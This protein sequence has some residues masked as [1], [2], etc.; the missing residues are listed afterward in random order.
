[1]LKLNV[2]KVGGA[3]IE[4]EAK[5]LPFLKDFAA[6]KGPKIL[7]HGGG[8][9]ASLWAE[10]MGI[11]VQM[12]DGRRI[13]DTATLEL[14]SGIYAGQVNKTIVAHL[15]AFGCNALGLSGADGNA[16]RA[17]KRPVKAIDYGFVGDVKEVNANL[18]QQ[19]LA[20]LLVPVCCAL[21]H[22]GN[23]QLLNTNADT[24]TAEIGKALAKQYAT[25]IS[26]CF[27]LPGVMED[28]HQADS[29]IEKINLESYQ[30]LLLN[31]TISAGMLPKLHNAFDA[32]H[33]GVAEVAIGSTKMINQ[34]IPY[35]SITLR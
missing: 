10:K 15:Q 4:E 6:L 19:L 18:Y 7:V 1:M 13:T 31:N 30:N 22:D 9:K 23:G 12:K 14:I 17:D 33:A 8:K 5:L 3:V 29:L 25:K 16:I 2:V 27:E 11:P 32:L 26:Y 20:E 35:T 34:D 21:T 28:I 24:I